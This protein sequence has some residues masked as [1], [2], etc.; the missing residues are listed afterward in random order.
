MTV[1]LCANSFKTHDFLIPIADLA[2][3]NFRVWQLSD[4]NV[5]SMLH[6]HLSG[7]TKKHCLFRKKVII[8]TIIINLD[9]SASETDTDSLE[10]KKGTPKQV[11]IDDAHTA[12]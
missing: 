8:I 6:V 10:M 11:C 7:S 2:D 1:L 4:I 9:E 5:L 3:A 12:V